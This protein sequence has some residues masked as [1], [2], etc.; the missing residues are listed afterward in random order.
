MYISFSKQIWAAVSVNHFDLG[1]AFYRLVKGHFFGNVSIRLGKR[2]I[3]RE[4]MPFPLVKSAIPFE[5]AKIPTHLA[6]ISKRRCRNLVWFGHHFKREAL[7]TKAYRCSS[8]V[9]GILRFGMD[10][11]PH[12]FIWRDDIRRNESRLYEVDGC[13]SQHYVLITIPS[14]ETRFIASN[15]KTSQN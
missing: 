1:S 11:F 12:V 9:F 2:A 15:K 10:N 4:M 6:F 13:Q 5:N 14:V 3:F 8:R 7:F